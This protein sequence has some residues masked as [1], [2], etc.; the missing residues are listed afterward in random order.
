MK[1]NISLIPYGNIGLV[2]P[3]ILPYLVESAE[4][5]KGR[6]GVDDILRFLFTGEMQLWLVYDEETKET[7]GQFIT[8]IKQ[9]P[10][11][12]M[13]VI[14]YAAMLPNHMHQ[15][16]DM[17]QGYAEHYAKAN[18]CHGIE[19]VGRRGWKRHAE[20]YGYQSQSVTYQRFFE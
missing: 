19:F 20:K 6:S 10:Q 1:L 9:Y 13:L 4:R 18:G 12:K 16:E 8:E 11:R 7:Y 17:M 3:A 15:I 5:S 14:Q 2:I